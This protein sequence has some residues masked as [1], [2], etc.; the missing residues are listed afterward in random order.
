[1]NV[2]SLDTPLDT[3]SINWVLIHL[4]TLNSLL[5]L[6]LSRGI[7]RTLKNKNR[8][9]RCIEKSWYWSGRYHTIRYIDI[10][11]TY[12]YFLCIEASLIMKRLATSL[13]FNHTAS[14]L[15]PSLSPRV[16]RVSGTGVS[17]QTLAFP[18]RYL[19]G[20]TLG[21]KCRRSHRGR[22]LRRHYRLRFNR[23]SDLV[24]R[25]HR[26]RSLSQLRKSY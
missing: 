7:K 23:T 15:D 16:T 10:E 20:W 5:P 17:F 14:P 2:K 25:R 18:F 19:S 8:A 1:M 4:V 24:G 3:Q 11:T 12:R 26:Y 9:W 6:L 22:Q 13:L 21:I